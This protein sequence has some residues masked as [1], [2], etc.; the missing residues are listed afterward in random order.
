MFRNAVQAAGDAVYAAEDA[1]SRVRSDEWE[2]LGALEDVRTVLGGLAKIK[3][4]VQSAAEEP[5]TS[6]SITL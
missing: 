1:L 5:N 3:A 2:R 4:F 6:P